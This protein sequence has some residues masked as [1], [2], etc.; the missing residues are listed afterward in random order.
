MDGARSS[1]VAAHRGRDG[2]G[3]RAGAGT[4]VTV[5][6]DGDVTLPRTACPLYDRLWP[7]QNPAPAYGEFTEGFEILDLRAAK[8]LLAEL[9]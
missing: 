7:R 8:A 9:N 1:G 6:S 3:T 2:G 4:S 5:R